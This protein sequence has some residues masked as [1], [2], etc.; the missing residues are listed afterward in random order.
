MLNNP[1]QNRKYVVSAIIVGVVL[2]Y[3]VRL[4][5]LQ[6]VETKYK[7]GAESNAL[8]HRTLY[9]PR[10]L[11]Y[12]RDGRLLV[13]NKPA[14]DINVIMREVQQLDTLELC[15]TLGIDRAYFDGRM[16]DIKNRRKNRGYSPYT[17]QTFMSKQMASL[18]RSGGVEMLVIDGAS[19]A[20]FEALRK[21][22]AGEFLWETDPY[23]GEESRL[24]THLCKERSGLWGVVKRILNKYGSWME[25]TEAMW[26]QPCPNC[27]QYS[28]QR[29]IK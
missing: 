7:E 18:L 9:A 24:F 27:G 28:P 29:S 6:V 12:D 14:Y 1:Y 17:P 13:Y 19:P 23:F 11:I 15:R 8:L 16:A 2:V 10:G 25:S 26:R 22:N 5:S 3:I 20:W 21:S 4:F